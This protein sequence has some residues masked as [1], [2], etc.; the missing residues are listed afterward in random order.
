M[1]KLKR[2]G[3]YLS[4]FWMIFCYMCRLVDIYVHVPSLKLTASLSLKIGR[5]PKGNN[6]MNQPSIFRCEL[7]LVSGRVCDNPKHMGKHLRK[8]PPP[9]ITLHLIALLDRPPGGLLWV[10]GGASQV[11]F[12]SKS[13]EI[14]R[15]TFKKKKRKLIV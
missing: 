15:S 7:L 1:R 11:Y 2:V 9:N 3:A 5:A 10:A 13:P 8:F 12:Q 6:R 4:P 14:Q